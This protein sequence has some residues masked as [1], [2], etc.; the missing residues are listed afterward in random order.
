MSSTTAT[1]TNSTAANPA[2]ATSTANPAAAIP[3]PDSAI[4]IGVDIGGTKIAAGAVTADGTILERLRVPTPTES[5]AAIAAAV[6]DLV[7][8]LTSNLGTPASSATPATSSVTPASTPTAVGIGSAGFVGADRNTISF[9]PNNPWHG[10]RLGSLV[11]EGT[12]LPVVVE[13]DANAA[14]WGEYRFGAAAGSRSAVVVTLGTGVGGGVI[15]DGQLIRGANGFAG[16]IGY[17]TLSENGPLC[18]CGRRGCWDMMGSGRALIRYATDRLAANPAAGRRV[19]ELSGVTEP[20]AE[21][22]TPSP[23][24]GTAIT[25]AATEGDPLALGAFA[26][27]GHWNTRGIATL[28]AMVDPEVVVLAGGV[29]EAGRVVL[30]PVV[31]GLPAELP[32]TEFRTLPSVRLAT[33]GNDAGLVGAADLARSALAR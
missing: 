4:T 10:E 15:L 31:A 8:R 9:G 29:A 27:L 16:E 2:A 28:V 14:A 11:S 21:I 24:K 7:R 32:A 26:D 12:G 20:L 18:G 6:S 22:P 25:A 1:S 5:G 19:L 30:D 33:L 17:I 13:N 23:I 3:A